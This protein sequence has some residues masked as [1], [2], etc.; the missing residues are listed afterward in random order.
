MYEGV[1]RFSLLSDR[2]PVR[3]RHK[4]PMKTHPKSYLALAL[5]T[6]ALNLSVIQPA[7]A[8][9]W[10]TNSPMTT[11]RANHT[12]TVL[13]NGKL[14]VVGGVNGTYL[15][16]AELYDPATGRWTTTGSLN[17]ARAYH[18]ATLLPN[19]KVLVVG[20]LNPVSSG[21][22][23]SSAELYDPATGTWTTTG[24]MTTIRGYHTAT[25]LPNGKV[26]VAG[27]YNFGYPTGAELYNPATGT[28]ATSGALTTARRYHTATLLPNGQVLVAGG[29]NGSSVLSSAELFDPAAGTWT[30]TNSLTTAR[31][32]HTATLLPNGKVLVAGGYNGSSVLSSAELF[33]PATGT[34]AATNSLTTTRESAYGDVAAQWE[35]IGDRRV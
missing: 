14:L 21:I 7:Q 16:S 18:T 22:Y 31:Q 10:V 24:S 34:W 33:D 23:L 11:Q 26:L 20:G 8:A 6:L 17:T 15:S 13:P 35:D 30:A 27:G 5:A 12:V 9:S 3:T 1:R 32:Y 4:P 29:Y 19:G 2:N 25:L 28:W